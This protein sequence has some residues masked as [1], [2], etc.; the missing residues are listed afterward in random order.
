MAFRIIDRWDMDLSPGTERTPPNDVGRLM[1][2]EGLDGAAVLMIG[3]YSQWSCL[4]G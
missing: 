4:T 2:P 3:S 1:P